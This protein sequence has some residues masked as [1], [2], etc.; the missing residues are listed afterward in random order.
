MSSE[1]FSSSL[2]LM[3]ILVFSKTFSTLTFYSVVAFTPYQRYKIFIKIYWFEKVVQ[4]ITTRVL[5]IIITAI[6]NTQFSHTNIDIS[7]H[8]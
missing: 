7:K 1:N 8:G 3:L 6:I 5:M 2:F 4:W